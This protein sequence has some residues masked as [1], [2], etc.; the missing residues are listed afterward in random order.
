MIDSLLLIWKALELGA[1]AAAKSVGGHVVKDAYEGL[2]TLIR[3]RLPKSTGDGLLNNHRQMTSDQKGKLQTALKEAG[4]EHNQEIV[5]AARK[6]LTILE[7]HNVSG[8]KYAL[9]IKGDAQGVVQGDHS[10][11]TMTFGTGPTKMKK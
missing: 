3:N 10:Q 5:D 1:E 11:V 2:K 9:E 6:L 7:Q 8:G 4:V